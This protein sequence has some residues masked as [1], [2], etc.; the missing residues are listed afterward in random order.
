MNEDATATL[1]SQGAV[2]TDLPREAASRPGDRRGLRRGGL[3]LALGLTVLSGGGLLLA[4][5]EGSSPT[6]P[7]ATEAELRVPPDQEPPLVGHQVTRSEAESYA[8]ATS[9]SW[10][11]DAGL[12]KVRVVA[13]TLTVD[14]G[15]E[16]PARVY[17]AGQSYVAG[18]APYVAR[19]ET[20]TSV[21]VVVSYLQPSPVPSAEFPA[22][23]D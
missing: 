5:D 9:R 15:G 18:W 17:E 11:T 2:T 20:A 21:E 22:S 14:G 13:G 3:L 10:S 12:H 4:V 8:A 1:P 6:P 19:N 16:G 7:P 23:V